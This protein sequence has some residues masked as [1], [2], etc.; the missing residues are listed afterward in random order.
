MF[1]VY[2][3][4]I[5]QFSKIKLIIMKLANFILSFTALLGFTFQSAAQDIHFSQFYA[6]PL[7]LNPAATGVMPRSEERRVGKEC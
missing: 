3:T 1:S 6:S 2:K 5:N 4:V 7:N